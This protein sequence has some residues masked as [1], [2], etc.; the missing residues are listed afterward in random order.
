M[1]FLLAIVK[2]G[3]V[4]PRPLG[5]FTADLGIEQLV[6]NLLGVFGHAVGAVH[7]PQQHFHIRL[8]DIH[9]APLQR[10]LGAGQGSK[11]IAF[12]IQIGHLTIGQLLHLMRFIQAGPAQG[13]E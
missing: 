10:H 1:V 9:L 4:N 2:A 8:V 7:G 6:E 3:K 12:E 5:D 13:T 11:I